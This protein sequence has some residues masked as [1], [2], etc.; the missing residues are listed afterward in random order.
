[1]QIVFSFSESLMVTL[2]VPKTVKLGRLKGSAC[3]GRAKIS[4]TPKRLAIHISLAGFIM[5]CSFSAFLKGIFCYTVGSLLNNTVNTVVRVGGNPV[6]K[7]TIGIPV[8]A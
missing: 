8:G 2:C 7:S 5:G 3:A 6:G 4:A 1:M